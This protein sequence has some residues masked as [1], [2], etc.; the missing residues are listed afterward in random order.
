MYIHTYIRIYIHTYIHTNTHA[1]SAWLRR[2]HMRRECIHACMCA[3]IHLSDYIGT[4]A[5]VHTRRVHTTS[6]HACV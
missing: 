6:M 3:C 2:D 1:Y 5:N 4:S